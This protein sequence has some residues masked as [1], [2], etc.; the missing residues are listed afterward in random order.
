MGLRP[1]PIGR[2]CFHVAKCIANPVRWTM[3]GCTTVWGNTEV[4][5]S[6]KPLSPS[7]TAIRIS[8]TPRLRSS[9]ITRSQNLAP[10]GLLDPQPENFLVAGAT[11]ADRQVQRPVADQTLIADFYAH[12]IEENNRIGRVQPAALPRRHFLQHRV[13]HRAHQV[14]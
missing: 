12:R 8:W 11:K 1:A 7:T 6:G 3:Q 9:V 5:A 14:R 10:L 2:R 4:I 13:S